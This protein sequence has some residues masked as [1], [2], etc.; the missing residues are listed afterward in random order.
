MDSSCR[1]FALLSRLRSLPCRHLRAHLQLL[2]GCWPPVASVYERGIQ[3]LKAQGQRRQGGRQPGQWLNLLLFPFP[4]LLA[5]VLLL[6]GFLCC[7]R[8]LCCCTVGRGGADVS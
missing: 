4:A 7:C 8:C 5:L 3:G 6:L 1:C 2:A